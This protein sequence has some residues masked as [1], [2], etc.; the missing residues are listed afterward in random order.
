MGYDEK[1]IREAV[2]A[3]HERLVKLLEGADDAAMRASTNLPGWTRGHVA[4]HVEHNGAACARQA[5]YA[6]QGELIEFYDG[7][8]PAAQPRIDAASGRPAAE[9]K[10]AMADTIA[11]LE[12]AFAQVEDWQAPVTYRDGVLRDVLEAR[13]REVEIHTVDLDLGYT[14][15]A[16]TSEFCMHALG[17]LS[18]R[19]PGELTVV[20]PDGTW[21]FGSGTPFRVTGELG[22]VVAWIAGRTPENTLSGDLPELGPWP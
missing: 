17:F 11:E 4:T 6:R 15:S 12:R 18:A 3:G 10:A 2:V 14:P 21:V 19:V 1:A 16:W 9:I 8:R 13:W 7:G 22:D 5:V 20:T